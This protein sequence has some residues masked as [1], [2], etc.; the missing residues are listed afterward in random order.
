MIERQSNALNDAQAWPPR[1]DL[2]FQL[3]GVLGRKPSPL[4]VLDPY[5]EVLAACDLRSVRRG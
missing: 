3:E 4:A 1:N 2:L 5:Q